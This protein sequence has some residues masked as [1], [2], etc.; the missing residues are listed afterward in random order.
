MTQGSEG[1]KLYE[2]GIEVMMKQ[3]EDNKH[4]IA[5]AYTSISELY[6]S[7]PLCDTKNAE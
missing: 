1:I 3:K 5:S 6:S 2:K 7:P 4:H